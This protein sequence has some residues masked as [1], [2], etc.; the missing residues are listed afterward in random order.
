MQEVDVNENGSSDSDVNLDSNISSGNSSLDAETDLD[1]SV[2]KKVDEFLSFFEGLNSGNN[3]GNVNN[4][5][6]K[7]EN[8]QSNQNNLA[9]VS[10]NTNFNLS[11]NSVLNTQNSNMT[12]PFAGTKLNLFG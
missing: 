12:N 3:N 5:F 6:I 11:S 1:D 7:P 9:A 8:I 10:Q 2:M 4:E